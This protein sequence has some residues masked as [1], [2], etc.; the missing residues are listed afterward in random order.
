MDKKT[1][2]AFF[3]AIAAAF[4]GVLLFRA[5]YSQGLW[6]PFL[7]G[8]A[9]AF[10]AMITAEKKGFILSLYCAAMTLLIHIWADWWVMYSDNYSFADFLGNY[11]HE[12][13]NMIFLAMNVVAAF[14][15]GY[16]K[17]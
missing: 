14:L 3:A 9:A 17:K 11:S 7:I 10:G 6:A 13:A 5:L 1:T 12:T 16:T 4:L 2:A 8:P 15:I